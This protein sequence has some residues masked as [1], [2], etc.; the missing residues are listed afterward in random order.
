MSKTQSAKTKLQ[1]FRDRVKAAAP[2]YSGFAEAV[3]IGDEELNRLYSFDEALI[4]YVDKIDAALDKLDESVSSN[5]GL[6]DAIG[7]LDQLTLEANDAFSLR[8][9]VL[10]NINKSLTA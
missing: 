3:K 9:D 5:E 8:E 7:S 4:R 10:T 6:D 1:T 2:G